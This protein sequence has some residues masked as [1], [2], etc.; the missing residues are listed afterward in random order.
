MFDGRTMSFSDGDV[1][2]IYQIDYFSRSGN[3]VHLDAHN[4]A[5][6]QIKKWITLVIASPNTLRV[7]VRNT[8]WIAEEDPWRGSTSG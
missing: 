8:P 7:D 3:T 5:L 2:E 6:Q 4:S 1:Q